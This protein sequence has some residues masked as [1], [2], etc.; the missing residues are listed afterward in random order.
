MSFPHRRMG[1]NLRR[2]SLYVIPGRSSRDPVKNTKSI[3][4]F[5]YFPGYRGQATV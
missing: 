2:I 5:Y 4:I 3:S 1:V